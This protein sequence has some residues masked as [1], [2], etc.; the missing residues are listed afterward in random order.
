M[1]STTGNN[2]V[3]KQDRR[4]RVRVPRERREALVEEFLGSG[5][6]AAEFARMAGVKYA[7]FANWVQKQRQ[8]QGARGP[9]AG[10]A[11]MRSTSPVEG[12]RLW[13]AVVED[14][15]AGRRGAG[16]NG[17]L[18]IEL[19]G[20]CGLRV[21]TPVQLAMAAELVKLVA[22]RSRGC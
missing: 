13:E 16:G 4:G 17:G 10:S 9:G 7:T 5:V 15:G 8:R 20:G 12:L 19:P 18:W 14:A 21:E 3:L 6:S 1:T 2:E 11:G 22:Q